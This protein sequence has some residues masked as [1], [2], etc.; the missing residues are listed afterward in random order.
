MHL[1]YLRQNIFETFP[2][3][4]WL[5]ECWGDFD[6]GIYEPEEVRHEPMMCGSQSGEVPL[7]HQIVEGIGYVERLVSRSEEL[8]GSINQRGTRASASIPSGTLYPNR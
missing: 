1:R 8:Q 6:I 5:R 3:N 7:I 4:D 2:K